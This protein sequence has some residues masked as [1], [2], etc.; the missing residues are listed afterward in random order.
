MILHTE[1]SKTTFSETEIINQWLFGKAKST[2]K[3]YLSV[4]AQFRNFEG[5][6]FNEINLSDMQR[7]VKFLEFKNY[8]KNTVINKINIVKSLFSFLFK[9][10]YITKNLMIMIQS[11]K[12]AKTLKNKVIELD[13]IKDS[14]NLAKTNR[15]KLIIK[16]LYSLGLRVSELI[17][18]KF[19]DIYSNGN[20]WLIDVVGKG[21]KLRTLKL[22]NSLYLELMTLK[23]NNPTD[24]IFV[25]TKTKKLGLPMQ[26]AGV[27]KLLKKLN[28]SITPHT[29]RHSF[30]THALSNGCSLGVISKALGHSSITTTEIYAQFLETESATDFITI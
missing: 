16:T 2:Q 28:Y 22:N 14:V 17:N 12:Q 10:Q 13:I 30:A 20:N 29:L 7:F 1:I 4:I 8:A 11:P 27:N 24:Y 19:T 21:D 6:T 9:M 15:D 3:T 18:L 26:R 5:K 25:T 23:E